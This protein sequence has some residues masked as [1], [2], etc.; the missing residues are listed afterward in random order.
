MD[1]PKAMVNMNGV[2]R[3]HTEV[4]LS[5]VSV[6]AMGYGKRVSTDY[7]FTRGSTVQIENPATGSILGIMDGHIGETSKMIIE[8]DMVS[9][10]TAKMFASTRGSGSVETR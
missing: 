8:V 4:T 9:C 5:R 10:S 1:Y 2:T 3:A 6:R 7:S